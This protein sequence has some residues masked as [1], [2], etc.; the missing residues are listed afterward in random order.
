MSAKIINSRYKY[1]FKK[2]N[3]LK[4]KKFTFYYFFYISKLPVIL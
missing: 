2:I 1:G 4:I 3:H